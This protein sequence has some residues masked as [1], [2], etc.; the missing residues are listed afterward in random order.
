MLVKQDG[1]VGELFGQGLSS[2]LGGVSAFSQCRHAASWGAVSC[3][4]AFGGESGTAM[5][6]NR[7]RRINHVTD[8]TIF[9][10]RQ[11]ACNT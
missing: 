5:G 6:A 3:V 4:G 8:N 2:A 10:T 1:V 9:V 11:C 7:Y